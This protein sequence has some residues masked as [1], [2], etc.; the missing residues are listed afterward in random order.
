MTDLLTRPSRVP[1]DAAAPRRPLALSALAAGAA[2]SMSVLLGC[3][4]LALAGW[5]GSDAGGYGTTTD[6]VRVGADGWL[7]GHGSRLDILTSS[8][9]VPLTFVPLG[10]SLL[11]LAVCFR[12]T[13]WAAQTSRV[14]DDATLLRGQLIFSG[15][16]TAV[17]LVTALLASARSA[18]PHLAAAV[19]GGLVVSLVGGAPGLLVGSG[20]AGAWSARLP[21]SAL[22]AARI[23]AATVLV[24]LAASAALLAVRVF[25]HL[26]TA[27]N[28]LSMLHI[29]TGGG[30][31]ATVVVAALT[32]NAVLL[33]S[34]YLLGPGFAV[35]AATAISPS[36]VAVGPLPAFPLLAA[37]PQP[38][39]TPWWTVLL[40]AVP[41][42]AAAAG[43]VG[44]LRR[45]PVTAYVAG[46]ARGLAGSAGGGLLTALLVALAGG[47][48][49]PGRMAEVGAPGWAVLGSALL[50]M[51]VGGLLAGLAMTWW[52]RRHWTWGEVDDSADEEP[53]IKL[54]R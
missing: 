44:V 20:H 47:S 37:L 14:D 53:T 49:G 50:A 28:T 32:P 39:P 1:N 38:G 24:M 17:V 33:T 35:G 5:F 46:A 11:C 51:S 18:Q 16:Y 22:V 27:A 13:R 48:V 40:L 7:L 41:V 19:V 30:L 12:V 29:D 2:A 4:A 15:S 54:N 9:P 3:V 10:L 23:A 52:T 43:A 31:L 6:A 26:G 36:T 21:E 42:L 8:G 34:A 45:H 25:W